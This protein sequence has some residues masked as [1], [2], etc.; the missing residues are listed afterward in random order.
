[1]K[2]FFSSFK[3]SIFN[4]FILILGVSF[5]FFISGYWLIDFFPVDSKR[6]IYS[7]VL[8]CLFGVIGYLLLFR[9][10]K[11][12]LADISRQQLVMLFGASI[13]IGSFLFFTTTANW[14]KSMRYVTL[15]LPEHTLQI[16]VSSLQPDGKIF[17][18]WVNTAFGDVSFN[19]F[20]YTGWKWE[21]DH[22]IL[23]DF[24]NN[25]LRWT[26]KTGEDTQVVFRSTSSNGDVSISWDGNKETQL[27]L[28]R[29]YNI[30]R[31]FHIPFYASKTWIL[32][33]GMLNF[34]ILSFP[35]NLFIWE[36]RSQ[37]LQS[38]DHA[39]SMHPGRLAVN[40]W[41]ILLLVI[42]LALLLRV[43]NLDNL[44]PVVDEYQ[45]LNAAKQIVAGVPWH[46][47]YQRGLL[48]VTFPASLALRLFGY[49]LWAARLVG[50]VFNAL[51][52][53]PL[54]LISRKINRP[55][56]I[57]SILLYATS[58]LIVVLSRV[59][60]EYAY[61]PFYFYWIVYGMIV[62]LERIRER[63]RDHSDWKFLF[64]PPQIALG[65]SLLIFPVYALYVDT[66]ST[67]KVI[68][69][70]YVVLCI[71]TPFMM[72]LTNWK[73]T[74]GIF[75]ILGVI[76]GG[77]YYW[78][79]RYAWAPGLNL[80]PINYFFPNPPQQWYFDRLVFIP[81]SVLLGGIA[82][83]ILIWR[84]NFVP[85]FLTA[86]YVCFVIFFTFFSVDHTE[87]RHLS[88]AHLWY[89][90]LIALGIHVC[91]NFLRTFRFFDKGL[92]KY[93][94]ALVLGAF[95]INGQQIVLPI[96]AH[97]PYM[98]ITGQ[99]HSELGQLHQ[100]LLV[101]SQK[102][103]VLI[104]TDIYSWYVDWVGE[105]RFSEKYIVGVDTKIEDVFSLVTQHASGWIVLDK[106][107]INQF[108][109]LPL[110]NF[111]KNNAIK[112]I[113]LFGDEYLWHWKNK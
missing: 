29:E 10:L 16:S 63:F 54:Y 35:L 55:V 46:N 80:S 111:P 98:P 78:L 87:P 68:L 72:S 105:P 58:P 49:K 103:D 23:T 64:G 11:K 110:E 113:G 81:A 21:K 5:G 109:F 86:L 59:V 25:Q 22:F 95:S 36:R 76:L 18:L 14:Q 4:V 92:N 69:I 83:S 97:G 13:F 82:G 104:S 38:L 40:D 93:L 27:L 73:N 112:Y 15:F 19:D 85:M 108:A 99:Y 79:G 42:I 6:L 84:K 57:L 9:W 67:F 8:L 1:M 75:I 7:T 61:Y 32:L 89:I 96:T 43:P 34:A 90:I 91:W 56:A 65:F 94:M 74:F 102:E 2:R 88:V 44:F 12:C 37:I 51:A 39:F 70:A 106:V 100:Y 50:V 17:L 3:I 62:I 66:F 107:W 60:R 30:Q 41:A 24:S 26:G 28:Q 48:L 71:A 47:L 101:N 77:G 33:L 31:S 20:D 53:I 45:Q 52:M